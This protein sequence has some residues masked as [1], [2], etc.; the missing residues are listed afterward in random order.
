MLQW[1]LTEQTMLP[2]R[3]LMEN[4][5]GSGPIS[6]FELPKKACL[7][8]RIKPCRFRD[9]DEAVVVH[10]SITLTVVRTI[11][12]TS[13]KATIFFPDVIAGRS[14]E[15]SRDV[16][17]VLPPPHGFCK[18]VSSTRKCPNAVARIQTIVWEEKIFKKMLNR[19]W[20]IAIGQL[21]EF[22]INVEKSLW[23]NKR[24]RNEDLHRRALNPR[25]SIVFDH[26][27]TSIQPLM[28]LEKYDL[29]SH[30]QSLTTWFLFL[31]HIHSSCHR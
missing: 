18:T 24:L 25:V 8:Y 3:P 12:L 21:Q 19:Q 9:G 17:Y 20:Y 13:S 1:R 27:I 4:V 31:S 29:P 30:F 5:T 23:T 2:V 16:W 28:R 14:K 7:Q 11:T 6:S 10:L 22:E 15:I 26:N